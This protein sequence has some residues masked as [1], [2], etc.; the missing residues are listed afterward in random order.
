MK[1]SESDDMKTQFKYRKLREI[2]EAR[3]FEAEEQ[4]IR[5]E[6]R[7]RNKL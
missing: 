5:A 4:R 7:K 1:H 6:L 3:K 2:D